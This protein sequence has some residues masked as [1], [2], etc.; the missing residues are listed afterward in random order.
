MQQLFSLFRGKY[1][2]RAAVPML[3]TTIFYALQ[4]GS[5]HLLYLSALPSVKLT[6][7]PQEKV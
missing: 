3:I 1:E 6:L 2:V 7:M 5:V 4:D